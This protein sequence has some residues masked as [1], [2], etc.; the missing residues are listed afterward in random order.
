VKNSLGE[1]SSIRN[2]PPF[3]LGEVAAAVVIVHPAVPGPFRVKEVR[4]QV[5]T[6]TRGIYRNSAPTFSNC[7]SLY[8]LLVDNVKSKTV[9]D[10][11][12]DWLP[13]GIEQFW[14]RFVMVASRMLE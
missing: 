7:V 1:N 6:L 4:L 8:H 11:P 10:N 5:E 9:E 14:V 12:A 2:A 13:I 3:I